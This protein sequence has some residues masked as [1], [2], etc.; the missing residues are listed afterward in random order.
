MGAEILKMEESEMA[1]GQGPRKA[2]SDEQIAAIRAATSER[3]AELAKR[4]GIEP[5]LVYYYR[6]KW[7]KEES[8]ATPA[9]KT[10]KKPMSLARPVEIDPKRNGTADA[11]INALSKIDRQAGVKIELT[12][13]HAEVAHVL[14]GLDTVQRTA[15]LSAGLRAAL[16]A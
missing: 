11:L 10:A 5:H 6:A 9:K 13:S 14:E 4:L 7:K 12:L 1:R 15:F 16:L 8:G 3:A 2:I